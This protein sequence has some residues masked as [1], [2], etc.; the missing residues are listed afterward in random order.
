MKGV[1]TTCGTV[2]LVG[3]G[4]GDPGLITVKGLEC[5]RRADVV[6]YDYLAGETLL[7]EA[8]AS[9]EKV[10]VGKQAG[11]H[12]LSQEEI[13]T[14][15]IV[16]AREGKAVVRLKG[17]DPFVFGRGGEEALALVNAGIPFEVVPGVTAGIAV[18]AYAGIPVTHRFLSSTLTLVTGHEDPLKDQSEVNWEALAAGTGTLVFFMG[19]RNLS[20]IVEQLIANGRSHDT[21]VALIRWGTYPEQRTLTGTLADIVGKA[22][23]AD[24]QP[25]VLIVI[26]DVVRLRERL[27]W[28]ETK[29][30]FGKRILVTRSREQAGNF[31]RRLLDLG[32]I[33]IECPTISI[34]PPLDWSPVDRAID[35]LADYDWT[36]FTSANGVEKFLGRLFEKGHDLRYLGHIRLCAIGPATTEALH[37]HH[38]IPDMRPSQNTSAAIAE[39]FSTFGSLSH[40]RILLPRA[41][42]APSDLPDALAGL[43]A[44]VCCVTAYRT[45]TPPPDSKVLDL[46]RNGGVDVITLTSS[47][48]V[49][50]LVELLGATD[51]TTPLNR[52]TVASIGPVT[53]NTLRE[54]G[55][56]VDIEADPQNIS[57]S[58]LIEAIL[59]YSP[60]K[61]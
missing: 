10:Y 5:L 21:P 44:K 37:R 46:L 57:I 54:L 59:R 40:V 53:S 2:Y 3:A 19:A 18:P 24:F 29:P 39:A 25:P 48:T 14:L 7:N 58:G 50:N 60:E 8:P 41:D 13:N 11:S 45:V 47:S 26:G 49:K 22:A 9:S 6:I 15:L 27:N 56:R 23:R 61:R 17:G 20:L 35:D 42:I 33:P 36:V 30:L 31:S 16:R 38:L 51:A 34:E 28:Y 32:A 55:V 1:N 12:T 43:G 4:P 52:V